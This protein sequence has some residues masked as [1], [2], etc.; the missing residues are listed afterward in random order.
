MPMQRFSVKLLLGAKVKSG[1]QTCQWHLDAPCLQVTFTRPGAS[2]GLL[3]TNW[4]RTV[5][6]ML[7]LGLRLRLQKA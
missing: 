2:S 1:M 3:C 6:K 5:A 4:V 7:A